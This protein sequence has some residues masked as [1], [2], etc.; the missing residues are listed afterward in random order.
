MWR[1][2][3]SFELVEQALMLRVGANVRSLRHAARLT[4][5]AAASKATIHWRH[6][7]K[8]EAGKLNTT[9]W[10][11]TRVALALEV[12]VELLFRDSVLHPH[13]AMLS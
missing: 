12:D 7:Q 5:Q 13:G 4:V 8:I 11:L 3:R 10:T 9:L 6:W 2:M 1:T